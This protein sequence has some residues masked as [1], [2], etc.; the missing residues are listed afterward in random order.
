MYGSLNGSELSEAAMQEVRFEAFGEPVKYAEP[1]VMTPRGIISSWVTLA[2]TSLF[3]SLV[4]VIV[5]ARAIYF[6]P[7]FA[8]E[9][10]QLEALGR[11]VRTILGA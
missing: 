10:W 2:G 3:W 4:A 5:V 7:D 8:G 1:R 11:T 6:V 9:L